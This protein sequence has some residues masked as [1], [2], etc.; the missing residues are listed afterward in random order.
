MAAGQEADHAGRDEPGDPGEGRA[1]HLRR[2]DEVETGGGSRS[3]I[4]DMWAIK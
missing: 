1:G 2:V 3:L 4:C